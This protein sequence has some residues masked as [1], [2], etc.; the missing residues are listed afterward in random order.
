MRSPLSSRAHSGHCQ[1]AA[2]APAPAPSPAQRTDPIAPT[3]PPLFGAQ[4]RSASLQHASRR[5]CHPP[6]LVP[7]MPQ[8]PHFQHPS[9]PTPHPSSFA[10]L[11][12][13][14]RTAACKFAT[15]AHPFT[16]CKPRPVVARIRPPSLQG[17]QPP[18]TPR[19]TTA[20]RA[21]HLVTACKYM[22][23]P[24]S[25]VSQVSFGS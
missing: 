20:C 25:H 3:P 11:C 1:T 22:P 17:T 16:A 19:H 6:P 10:S 23:H 9:A 5:R 14:L 12:C 24:P 15:G 18:T 13:R 2:V 21:C 4:K 8:A 7:C